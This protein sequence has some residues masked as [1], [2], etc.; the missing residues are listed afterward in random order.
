MALETMM[1][2]LVMTAI[3]GGL[4]LWMGTSFV[5]P[6]DPTCMAEPVVAPEHGDSH[7]QGAMDDELVELPRR[8]GGESSEIS[9]LLGSL[10]SLD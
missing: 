4:A 8:D 3:S 10:V 1:M 6:A 5:A 7:R 9:P 2:K